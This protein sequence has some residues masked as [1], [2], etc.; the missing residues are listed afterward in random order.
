MLLNGRSLVDVLCA[1]SWVREKVSSLALLVLL[2]CAPAWP[3]LAAESFLDRNPKVPEAVPYGRTIDELRAR[4]PGGKPA[5]Q[6]ENAGV[7]TPPE[8]EVSAP[9]WPQDEEGTDASGERRAP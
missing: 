1:V 9:E 5:R 3:G 8:D 7:A 2:I 6:Q 4:T